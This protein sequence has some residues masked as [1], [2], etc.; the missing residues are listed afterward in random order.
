MGWK[1]RERERERE[2]PN[3]EI[4]TITMKWLFLLMRWEHL[5]QKIEGQD[6]TWGPRR[7]RFIFPK[8]LLMTSLSYTCKFGMNRRE[9]VCGTGGGL[10]QKYQFQISFLGSRFFILWGVIYGEVTTNEKYSCD[11]SFLYLSSG[12]NFFL[13]YYL[14]EY[15][16]LY[17]N[18]VSLYF[19]PT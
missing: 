10:K 15:H 6:G 16:V 2:S 1:E 19:Y 3:F 12:I 14:L 11:M 18:F 5:Q 8:L 17:L 13:Y 7:V 9:D 4:V